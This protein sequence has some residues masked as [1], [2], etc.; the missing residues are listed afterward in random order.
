[1]GLDDPSAEEVNYA[2]AIRFHWLERRQSHVVKPVRPR[3]RVSPRDPNFERARR[4]TAS[5]VLRTF[6]HPS[7]LISWRSKQQLEFCPAPDAHFPC[8]PAN[9]AHS[10]AGWVPSSM[11]PGRHQRPHQ[12][13]R[14]NSVLNSDFADARAI[15]RV[16]RRRLRSPSS[17]TP[18][19]ASTSS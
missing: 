11:A 2:D 7:S 14:M 4:C 10:I 13:D 3:A 9:H 15:R 5:G 17:T 18:R 19:G 8:H 16:C 12:I 1:M 6:D